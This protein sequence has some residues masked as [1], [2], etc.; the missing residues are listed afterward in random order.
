[1]SRKI[2]EQAKGDQNIV[3]NRQDRR[4]PE[5]PLESKGNI[6]QHACQSIE[7][8]ANCL[9]A[10]LT[11][12]LAANNGDV[13]N[14][15]GTKGEIVFNG[16]NDGRSGAGST[17]EGIEIGDNAVADPVAIIEETLCELLIPVGRI[18]GEI[19]GDLAEQES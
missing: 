8:N 4:D 10:E 18:D 13:A 6:Y 12:N 15:E 17:G 7:G 2:F 14:G 5:N 1:M 16:G 9:I 19:R 11:A 3:K